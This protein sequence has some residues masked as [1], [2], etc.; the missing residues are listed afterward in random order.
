MGVALALAILQLSTAPTA[1]EQAPTN[2]ILHDASPVMHRGSRGRRSASLSLASSTFIQ[3]DS[4]S[5]SGQGGASSN[6]WD[7]FP[8]KSSA[9]SPLSHPS[10]PCDISFILWVSPKTSSSTFGYI[11]LDAHERHHQELVTAY[12]I[13]ISALP[14]PDFDAPL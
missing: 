12:F 1:Q 14:C 7:N 2:N 8:S 13:G 3:V 5:S 10:L 6:F 4:P 9:T 11:F